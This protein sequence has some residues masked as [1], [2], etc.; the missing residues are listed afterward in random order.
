[1]SPNCCFAVAFCAHQ[2]T[3]VGF[4]LSSNAGIFFSTDRAET[5]SRW[6]WGALRAEVCFTGGTPLL[7]EEVYRELITVSGERYVQLS[8]THYVADPIVPGCFVGVRAH[9]SQSPYVGERVRPPHDYTVGTCQNSRYALCRGVIGC[10]V[11][12]RAW[13]IASRAGKEQ[14]K[15]F[16]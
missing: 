14:C 10:W 7:N 13:L 1:M 8:Y 15:H 2:A 12:L 5:F 6:G 9:C 4:L 16:R 11:W 3:H